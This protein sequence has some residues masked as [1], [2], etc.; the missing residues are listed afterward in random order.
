MPQITSKGNSS[1]FSDF[2]L[3]SNSKAP[4]W[5]INSRFKIT[6][7]NAACSLMFKKFY[8]TNI[9]LRKSFLSF[10]DKLSRN[11]W[12]NNYQIAFNG[13]SF[14]REMIFVHSGEEYY[15]DIT[16][17]PVI[18]NER[19][20]GVSVFAKDISSYRNIQKQL[21]YKV[22]ELNAF[23]FKVTHD[24]RSPL[25]SLNGLVNIAKKELN[26]DPGKLDDYFGMIGRS[27]AKMDKLLVDLLGITRSS[28]GQLQIS[29]I[30]FGKI[31]SDIFDSLSHFPDFESIKVET[32]ITENS[33][34]YS[35]EGMLYSIMQNVI[36]NAVK[37]RRKDLLRNSRIRISIECNE[38][39]AFI[40]IVDN[41]IGIQDDYQEKV[42]DMF[43]RATDISFGTGL[44]LYIVKTSVE[45][46][47]G[48]ISLTSKENEGTEIQIVLTNLK[49]NKS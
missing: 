21:H 32:N 11:E 17:N 27:T 6:S 40:R 43:Y 3:I 1:D 34:F 48:K 5:A 8:D 41:G 23:V 28:N 33:G 4:V 47:K 9:S 26:N 49:R 37:Y 20:E 25:A 44:G 12:G 38:Q 18:I 45:K 24:L 2:A 35:D 42:F 15:F 31:T 13:E 46:M 7:F 29:K 19:V 30:D 39:N 16:F 10:T 14:S 22:D 36:D